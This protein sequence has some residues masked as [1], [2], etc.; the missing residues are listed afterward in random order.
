MPTMKDVAARAGVSTTT[1]SY[2]LNGRRF[3]DPQTRDRVR[4]AIDDLQYDINDNARNLRRRTTST[5]ALIVPDL[6]NSFWPE[7]ASVILRDAHRA[8]FDIVLYNVDLPDVG[9]DALQPYMRAI[10]GKR[11]DAVI[12][13]ETLRNG[14]HSV[15]D[16]AA[17]GTPVVLIG[18]TAYPGTD[19]VYIDDYA[20]ARDLMGHLIERGH[21]L[22]AHIT[23]APEM[24]ST[25]ERLRGYR[26]SLREA[27]LPAGPDLEVQ[28]TF[29]H[30]GG[31][32]AMR[33][34][35]ARRPRPTAVFAANDVT[36][37]GAMGACADA[38][39]AIP[40]EIAIAGFDDIEIARQVRPALTTVSH[41]QR[42][43]GR[44]AIRLAIQA[45]ERRIGALDGNGPDAGKRETVI[46][47]HR[48]IVR[49]SA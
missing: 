4:A 5:L 44:E 48:L 39:V 3:V 16:L 45:H 31:Y 47:P 2:V 30:D 18:G 27:G 21:T 12:Y 26:D 25:R 41:G 8:G 15:D 43:L 36:A 7:L 33:Q 20:A 19:R 42:D 6:V 40:D 13:S 10:R 22:I 46:V 11:Y 38:G 17:T 9:P 28:G 35:L 37:L 24:P 1:V 49:E 32:A 23:G 34:I 29:L 14:S